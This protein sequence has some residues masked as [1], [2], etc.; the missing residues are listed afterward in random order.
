MLISLLPLFTTARSGFPSRL[1]SPV[2]TDF[3]FGPAENT[4]AG[5]GVKGNDRPAFTVRASGGDIARVKEASPLYCAR[6]KSVP[7]LSDAVVKLAAPALNVAVPIIFVPKRNV[8]V[9]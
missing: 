7:V 4:P 3:G 1:K 8:T 9:P 5:A 6:R 2:I